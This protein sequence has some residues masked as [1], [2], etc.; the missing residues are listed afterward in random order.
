MAVGPAQQEKFA[1]ALP[2]VLAAADQTPVHLIHARQVL[3]PIIFAQV[4]VRATSSNVTAIVVDVIA[5]IA[6]AVPHVV[7]IVKKQN[8][9]KGAAGPG[10]SV[11]T[12]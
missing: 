2:M 1:S 8:A 10:P 5:P 9:R 7:E 11:K 6:L 12:G 3:A 4:I